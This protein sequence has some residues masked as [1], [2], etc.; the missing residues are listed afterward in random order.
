MK[1]GILAAIVFALSVAFSNKHVRSLFDGVTLVDSKSHAAEDNLEGI[2]LRGDIALRIARGI[3]GAR[4]QEGMPW[5]SVYE[6]RETYYFVADQTGMCSYDAKHH[7]LKMRKS[8]GSILLPGTAV[9]V[10]SGYVNMRPYELHSLA[11]QGMSSAEVEKRI[12]KP[13]RQK[14]CIVVETNMLVSQDFRIDEYICHDTSEYLM[15]DGDA[16][17]TNLAQGTVYVIS[18]SGGLPFS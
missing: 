13:Y 7:G 11:L 4:L 2:N 8:D 6:D 14:H 1:Y 9:W 16:C 17:V 18:I 15:F 12:G 5:L 10:K 3:Y